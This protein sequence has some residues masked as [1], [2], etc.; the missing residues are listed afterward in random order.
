MQTRY[1]SLGMIEG[2]MAHMHAEKT[3]LGFTRRGVLR[4]AM[5]V[6]ALGVVA[7]CRG[8]NNKNV[9]RIAVPLQGMTAEFMQLWLRGAQAHPAIR[10]GLASITVFDGRMDALTQANQFDTII[11]QRYDAIIFIPVDI[12]AGVGPAA[13]AKAAGIPL[14]GSNTLM[15][16]RSLYRCYIGSDGVI[17]GED[18]ARAVIT[19]LGGKG[20]VVI[21]EGIIG[22]SAQ[23][24]RR[25]GIQ[26]ILAQFP[27]VKVLEMKAANWSRAE[28][29]ALMENWLT[30]H[31]S[32]INGVISQNDEMALGALEAL[33]ARAI[34]LATH[35]VGGVDG[36]TD[37]LDAVKRG[38]MWT[39]LQD[40]NAQAQGS[41][42]LALRVLVGRS[43]QPMSDIWQQ[44]PGKLDWG[45]GTRTEYMVPWTAVTS[46]NVDRLLAVRRAG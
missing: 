20:N 16:D 7:G 17:S 41:I 35:P 18:V 6:G 36:L 24:E 10:N 33:K 32:A 43:Y 22:H 29:Q 30:A 3:A 34:D 11:T 15:A 45:D 23:I 46:E 44:Y 12:Q 39:T 26:T 28:G 14:I 4:G 38:E 1:D 31:G 19:K 8:K 5:A 25:Q 13:Q 9:H 40:A 27:N 2:D 37:A 42:D 21:L